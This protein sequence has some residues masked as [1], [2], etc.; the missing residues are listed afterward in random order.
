[1]SIQYLSVTEKAENNGGVIMKGGDV[2]N[3]QNYLNMTNVTGVYSLDGYPYS[4]VPVQNN[5]SQKALNSSNFVFAYNNQ[6]AL[7]KGFTVILNTISLD[8]DL[9]TPGTK[10][11]SLTTAIHGKFGEVNRLDTTAIRQNRYNEYTGKFE[12][13]YPGVSE[14]NFGNDVAALP[15]RANPGILSFTLGKTVHTKQYNAK[16]G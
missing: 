3:S 15:S 14:D 16:T 6:D 4:S 5:D 13:G 1:M 10:D 2:I 9:K 8:H 7:V 11:T 12:L